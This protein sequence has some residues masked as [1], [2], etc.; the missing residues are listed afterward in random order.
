MNDAAVIR[1]RLLMAVF[2][3]AI[4]HL[5]IVLGPLG[6]LPPGGGFQ[7]EPPLAIT[8]RAA[9]DPSP[10]ERRLRVGASDT[11]ITFK[12]AQEASPT[13]RH[14]DGTTTDSPSARYLQDWIAQAEAV[15]NARYPAALSEAGS[16]GQV[17]MA[18][19]LRA[20]GT[21]LD[22]DILQ[23]T[24]TPALR[25]AAETLVRQA[26]PY[27]PVPEAVLAGRETLVITRAWSFG[28]HAR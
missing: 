13:Q 3:S 17:I 1:D 10:T 18:V 15:G 22:T 2:L 24:G 6:P 23:D 14:I 26:A 27:P 4:V 20:D 8:L 11:R 9:S 12:R 25:Q 16:A 5:I 21:V 19:T 7:D 28:D